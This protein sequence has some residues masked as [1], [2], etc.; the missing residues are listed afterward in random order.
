MYN[1]CRSTKAL[2]WFR[3]MMMVILLCC[4][5]FGSKASHLAGADLT[6]QSLGNG[7]YL[8]TYTLYRDC[9]GITVGTQAFLSIASASCG[10]PT[11]SVTMTQVPGTG[12]EITPSCTTSTTTCNGGTSPGIQQYQYTAL[13]SLPSPCPDWHLWVDDC[14]RNNAI[15]TVQNAAGEGLY[16]E[17]YLDNTIYESSSPTFSNIPIVFFCIGQTNYFNH[18]AVDSDGDSLAYYFIPPRNAENDPVLFTAGHST[19]QPLISNP[20]M[21]IDAVTGDVQ[22]DPTQPEI[23][24]MSVLV[25]EYR[26]GELIGRVMRDIQ[27]YTV[28]CSNTLPSISGV[29]GSTS[30][31]AS[32][33]AG[34][35][36][37]CFNIN[38]DDGN[39]TDSLYLTWNNGI[40][41]ATFNP[42]TG[43]RPIGQFCW[44]PTPADAR[45]NPYIF[46]VTVHDNSCPSPGVQTYSFS[47]LVSA[48]NFSV[49][50]SPSVS[51][52]G[53][54]TGTATVI[55]TG[56]APFTYDW[57]P[58]TLSGSSVSGLS[59]GSYSVTVTDASGCAGSRAFT[60]T[61]PSAVQVSTSSASTQCA[62]ATGTATAAGSGGTAPYSYS[63]DTNPVQT[64]AT[65]T[66]LATGNYS[67][68]VT[69]ANGCSASSSVAVSSSGALAASISSQDATCAGNDGSCQVTV[70]AGTAPF[71]Y[72][73]TPNVSTSDV[74]T[75][76]SA[77]NYSVTVTDANGCDVILNASISA[78]GFSASVSGV[79]DVTCPGGSDGAASVVTQGGNGPYSYM[80]MPGMLTGA[81]ESALTAGTYQIEVTDS[82]GCVAYTSATIGTAN[83]NPVITFST[84][85]DIC[86]TAAPVVLTLASPAGGSYSGSGVSGGSFDPAA[87]GAGVATIDYSYTDQNG[88]SSSASTTITVVANPIVELSDVSTSCVNSQP[89]VLSTGRPVGGTYS[90]PG[91]TNGVFDPTAAGGPGS[92]TIYYEYTNATGCSG[93]DSATV[94]VGNPASVSITMTPGTG[95]SPNTVYI[96]YT[97]SYITLTANA[98]LSGLSYQ[99]YLNG[100]A[101]TGATDSIY[102]ASQGG[103]YSVTVSDAGGCSA[104]ATSAITVN[105]VDVRCGRDGRKV[106]L[107]HVPPGNPGNA[108]PLCIA[109]SAVPAHLSLHPGDCLGPCPSSR[110]DGSEMDEAHSLAVTPNP[111]SSTLYISFEVYSDQQIEVTIC[112]FEGRL[113]KELVNSDF[114]SD[115]HFHKEFSVSGLST[116]IYFVKFKSGET[117]EYRKVIKAD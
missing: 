91:V 26:N 89:I 69:D 37:L 96:G 107:C 11:Q 76:L 35:A 57:T 81:T 65:A 83:Q 77:G 48:L 97:Q 50:N 27:V 29:N 45:P 112:D 73:W 115:S 56:V 10:L 102:L 7:T 88:C 59:A 92:Y 64:T 25:E 1:T 18:G 51:C 87:A 16:I 46:T 62:G 114:A 63:W 106:V 108:Q 111:F 8:V 47:I 42:G 2:S 110:I 9:D 79:Q 94:T 6:Y 53:D 31:S 78:G 80:W 41:G 17:A 34:A 20:P 40:P 75:G 103:S 14:C 15:N 68:T 52:N 19:A 36:P 104:S 72:V 113:V 24:I 12:Q 84:A 55:A 109:P 58:N 49:T 23:G 33:C 74:A 38:S 95:C 71:T 30:F 105:S 28:A 54:A 3:A 90:G 22:I 39:S 5:A 100:Q 98:S 67:C 13:V 86:E 82:L 101:I 21:T 116:G 32:A 93:M 44:S 60:I 61:Q 85:A 117:V 4:G 99:W 66:G 70:G 43:S